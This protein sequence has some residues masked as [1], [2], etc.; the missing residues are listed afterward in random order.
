VTQTLQVVDSVYVNGLF[1]MMMG[2]DVK[3]QVYPSP[4]GEVLIERHGE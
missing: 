2:N 4:F 3:A 1:F